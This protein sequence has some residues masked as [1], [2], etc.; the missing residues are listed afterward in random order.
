M[1]RPANAKPPNG[2]AASHADLIARLAE[3]RKQTQLGGGP[4]R[5]EAQHAKGK[6]TA[7]ERIHRLLDEGT[8]NEIDS[9]ITHRHSDF[10]MADQRYAGDSVVV[11]FG[12]IGGRRVCVAAQDFTVLGGSFSE[13]QGQKAAKIMDLALEA[14]VPMINLNDSVGARI[15]EGVY[16]LAG[17]SE[18]FWRN[19]QASGVIPQISVMLGPCAGGSVY[20]PGLTDFV[21]MTKG[22]SH[23]F[24]TGPEVIKTVTSEE[25]DLETLGGAMTHN[26]VSGVAHF[27]AEGEDD[28][29]R[30]TRELL[31]YLPSN[32]AEPPPSV[33]PTDDP[34]RMDADLNTLVPTDPAMPYDMKE[35]IARIFDHESFFEVHEYF[36]ANAI[37][38]FARLHGQVVGLVAQQPLNL[39]GVIDIDASD[40]IARFIRFADAFNI[41]LITFVD[42]PGFMPGSMQEHGGIIRH[43]AKIV[44]A[45][46]EATVPKLAVITRKAYGGA[47]IVMSSKYIRAD[48]VYAWPT[49][50]IA[51]MGAEGAVNILYGKELKQMKENAD[52]ERER[53]VT[54]FRDKFAGPYRS[55]ASG[56]VDDILIPAETRPRLIA[57]LE[58]L[59]D[60]QASLPAKKHGTMPL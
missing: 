45:Y 40:K 50:E 18:L 49:A 27:A 46:S 22:T 5:I 9:Y 20:S 37:V 44:Y 29:L 15:Q 31:S 4:S 30:L 57:A 43:G 34:R 3:Q 51:V 25:I 59:R 52:A 33:S 19:T 12:K 24:I 41:P 38:G 42:C 13:A 39:A 53:L 21:I 60:K 36:A 54:E 8:F 47:Y 32:N 16:S 58:L 17:Y 14:G 7:R 28:A 26:T 55:A 2:D 1:T 23:M 35:A 11:G 10:G 6:L 48:L 56:H